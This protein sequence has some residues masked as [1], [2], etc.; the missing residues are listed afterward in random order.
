M[1]KMLQRRNRRR[2]KRVSLARMLRQIGPRAHKAFRH[3]RVGFWR[4]KRSPEQQDRATMIATF[5]FIGVFAFGA[6]DAII[7]GGA[8]LGIASAYA[9]E[10]PAATRMVRPQATVAAPVAVEVIEEAAAT[11]AVEDE[12]IDYSQ[13]TEELLGGPLLTINDDAMIEEL[14]VDTDKLLEAVE[15]AAA[16]ATED[17]IL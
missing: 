7:T 1:A 13:T 9:S 11:K 6:V 15:P 3:A 12:N 10:M 14:I 17:S 8:D 16:I 5:A 2:R 4:F